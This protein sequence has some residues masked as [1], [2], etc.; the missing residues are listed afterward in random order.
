MLSDPN[1]SSNLNYK[2]QLVVSGRLR[3]EQKSG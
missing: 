3:Q 2:T 1:S